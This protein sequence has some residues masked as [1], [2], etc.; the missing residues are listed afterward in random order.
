M[1]LPIKIRGLD[2][3]DENFIID[4]FIKSYRNS[5]D[6]QS[7]ARDA[8]FAG[9]RKLFNRIYMQAEFRIACNKDDESEIY[10]WL[11]AQKISD[12]FT[13][14]YWANVKI[15]FRKFGIARMLAEPFLSTKILYSLRSK[16]TFWMRER[17][18]AEYNPFIIHEVLK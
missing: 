12:D 2:A 5:I 8:Y 9:A 17:Q 16:E 15:N 4:S 11:A 7:V 1:E 13:L 6:V 10:G 14:I 18:L 3:S